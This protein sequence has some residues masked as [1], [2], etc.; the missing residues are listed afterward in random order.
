MQGHEDL[1]RGENL[2]QAVAGPSLYIK[3]KLLIACKLK[4]NQM[5]ARLRKFIGV[6]LMLFLV[7]LYAILAVSIATFTLAESEWYI[8]L[9]YFFVTGLLWVLPAMWLI[10][11]MEGPKKASAKP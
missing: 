11:W 3:G 5:P 9:I 1:A 8:H 10:K 4:G 7:G 6:F 2:R